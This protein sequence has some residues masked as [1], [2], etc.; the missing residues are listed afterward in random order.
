MAA[1]GRS[2]RLAEDG[3]GSVDRVSSDFS[4]GCLGPAPLLCC[5]ALRGSNTVRF[6]GY[7]ALLPP[8]FA[9]GV[10]LPRGCLVCEGRL[11]Q[12]CLQKGSRKP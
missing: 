7:L 9:C 6:G 10:S 5:H 8:C 1:K 4:F 2:A 3:G 11:Q 12:K